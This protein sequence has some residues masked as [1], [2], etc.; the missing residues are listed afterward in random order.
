MLAV[1]IA[2][3]VPEKLPTGV[4]V[5]DDCG[6]SQWVGKQYAFLQSRRREVGFNSTF[7]SRKL[8]AGI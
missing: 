4:E 6:I 8:G 1:L 2:W 5:I 7:V 3:S